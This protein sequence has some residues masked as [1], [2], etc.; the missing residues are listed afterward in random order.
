[1]M[2][3]RRSGTTLG[4]AAA[5][6]LATAACEDL[7]TSPARTPPV[8]VS[9]STSAAPTS[10]GTAALLEDSS[11]AQLEL[12]RVDLLVAEVALKRRDHDHCEEE[13][14]ACERFQ[15]GPLVV[16]LPLDGGV[17][18]PFQGAVEPGV[19]EEL[20]V[21]IDQPEDD[22][23]SRARF[24]EDHPEWPRKAT[25]RVVGTYSAD[26][27]APEPFDLFLEVDAEIE[28]E[29]GSAL[30]VEGDTDPSTINLT[31]E[32]DVARWFRASGGALIDPRV[33]ASDSELRERVEENIEESF[34]AFEDDDRDGVRADDDRNDDDDD[35]GDDRG[36][37]SDD[38]PD[39]GDDHGG[40][41]DR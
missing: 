10:G 5:I 18:T 24:L 27:G 30:V 37:G 9:F 3:I 8:T 17:V 23:G 13:D 22:D 11:G 40:D 25:V 28:R 39:T 38:D 16:Q 14:D 7:S 12:E 36:R 19:Y 26:G 20:E 1:M 34:E 21:E 32:V 6:I 29:F 4:T 2:K 15:A 41:D 31:V 35:D 33:I